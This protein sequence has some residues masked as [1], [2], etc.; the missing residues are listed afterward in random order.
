MLKSKLNYNGLTESSTIT[1]AL[2]YIPSKEN[3]NVTL[4]CELDPDPIPPIIVSFIV[5]S[6]ALCQLEPSNGVCKTSTNLCRSLYNASCP[7]D[8]RYSIQVNVSRAWSG[9][10]VVCQTIYNQ[11]NRVVFSVKGISLIN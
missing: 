5:D 8:T 2:V 9:S 4:Q 10:S 7:S 1:C 6:S 11:S 3:Q